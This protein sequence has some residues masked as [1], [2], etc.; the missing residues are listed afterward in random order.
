MSKPPK[1][2]MHRNQRLVAIEHELFMVPEPSRSRLSLF[3]SELQER[4]A[5]L[6]AQLVTLKAHERRDLEKFE[7]LEDR[8]K[9]LTL[10]L[11][12]RKIR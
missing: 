9:K 7:K 8:V 4:V 11:N 3:L 5:G 2:S 6:E 10:R 1:K 12:E